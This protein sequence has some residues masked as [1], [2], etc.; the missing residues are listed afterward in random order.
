MVPKRPYLLSLFKGRSGVSAMRGGVL[1]S[2]WRTGTL[3]TTM[4]ATTSLALHSRRPTAGTPTRPCP[5]S[6]TLFL[7]WVATVVISGALLDGTKLNADQ[8]LARLFFG[9][10]DTSL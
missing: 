4:H 3:G 10:A 5:A 7:L 1:V 2:F 8:A 6:E 9:G